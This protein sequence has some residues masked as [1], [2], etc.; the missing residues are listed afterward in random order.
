MSSPT[1]RATARATSPRSP[2]R[3]GGRVGSVGLLAAVAVG[4]ATAIR[5]LY[6]A[7]FE[8][9]AFP[10][11]LVPAVGTVAALA[12]G[13]ALAA[14]GLSTERPVVRVGLLFAGVFGVLA[15]VSG[16]ATVAAAVAI[17]V[18]A[19]LAFARA[20]GPPETYFELRRGVIALTFA[21][22][23]GLSLAATAGLV[24][25]PF[26]AAGSAAFLAGVT[27]L[28]V[29]AEGDPVAL[30]AGALAFAGVIAASAAAP[31]VTGSA[32]LAGFAV[33]GSPHLLVATAAFGG[34]AAAV[35]G[36]RGGDA[37]LAIGAVLLLLAGVPA[38]PGAATA[39]CLGAA[40]A[41]LDADEFFGKADGPDEPNATEVNTR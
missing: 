1:K 37:R 12:S 27:L 26:R 21:L 38:T 36:F 10:P 39:V 18:G 31:Y 22:A 32:L 29:R 30:G 16:A 23:V 40:L 35:S 19:A 4:V 3:F 2:G 13:V 41:V 15:T 34:V 17:P 28:A 7:P 20:M 8:P 11:R 5:V 33:V 24:G 25:S 6:N 9:V 14:V